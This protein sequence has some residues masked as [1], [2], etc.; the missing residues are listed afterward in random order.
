MAKA[1]IFVIFRLTAFVLK[2]YAEARPWIEID[3]KEISHPTDWLFRH[4]DSDG[5]FPT[6]GMLHHKA[7]KGG[8]KTPATLT[9][10]VLIAL[11]EAD[12]PPSDVRATKASGCVQAALD[13]ITDSYSL[14]IISYMFAKLRDTENYEKVMLRLDALAVREGNCACAIFIPYNKFFNTTVGTRMKL[15]FNKAINFKMFKKNLA[16]SFGNYFS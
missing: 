15:I 6:V 7:M 4:Q 12:V 2:S 10:Y 5:C 8:V 3:E 14:A 13:D 11:L 1:A 16:P 9:A